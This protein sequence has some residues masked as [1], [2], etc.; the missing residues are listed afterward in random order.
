MPKRRRLDLPPSLQSSD[1]L[2]DGRFDEDFSLALDEN[3]STEEG[4]RCG[5]SEAEIETAF[6]DYNS[7]VEQNCYPSRSP[8]LSPSHLQRES[9]EESLSEHEGFDHPSIYGEGFEVP[10]AL[11]LI[12]TIPRRYYIHRLRPYSWSHPPQYRAALVAKGF[13]L[14]IT[15]LPA[16]DWVLQIANPKNHSQQLA[17]VLPRLFDCFCGCRKAITAGD[18]AYFAFL[19]LGPFRGVFVPLFFWQDGLPTLE[20][21]IQRIEP[22]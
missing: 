13:V 19:Q 20:G 17:I 1:D 18:T 22:R 10:M 12:P 16:G 3:C 21:Y 6:V 11:P 2:G 9:S 8:S 14:C 4:F 15:M 7:I 5:G